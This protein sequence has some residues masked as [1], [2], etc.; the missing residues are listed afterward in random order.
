MKKTV[1]QLLDTLSRPPILV[2]PDWSAAEN[3]LRLFRLDTDSSKFVTLEKEQSD[4]SIRPI[5]YWSRT[6]YPNEDNWSV[7]EQGVGA[8]VWGVRRLPHSLYDIPFVIYTDHKSL[9]NL[10]QMAE[11][12]ARVQR[13]FEILSSYNFTPKY[14]TG[15]QNANA[16]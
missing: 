5:V 6:T 2:F 14:R 16:N 10:A 11:H 8:I 15:P 4:A 1:R 13:W 12:N 9:E 3:G 7:M